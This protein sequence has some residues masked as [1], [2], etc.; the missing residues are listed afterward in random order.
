M[1][2]LFSYPWIWIRDPDHKFIESGSTTLVYNFI[3]GTGTLVLTPDDCISRATVF[4]KT[5]GTGIRFSSKND[6]Y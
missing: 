5:L 1:F 6:P 3:I 4:N 2:S